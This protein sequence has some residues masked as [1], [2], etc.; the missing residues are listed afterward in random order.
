VPACPRQVS[1]D[2]DWLS[3]QVDS[4]CS[5]KLSGGRAARRFYRSGGMHLELDV[6]PPAREVA[7]GQI[8]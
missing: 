2:Y 6:L 1:I 4:I 5:V 8:G 3:S 7:V